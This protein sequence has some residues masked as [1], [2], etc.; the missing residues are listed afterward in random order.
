[1]TYKIS[2]TATDPTT[3]KARCRVSKGSETIQEYV[4]FSAALQIVKR[5]ADPGDRL[6]IDYGDGTTSEHDVIEEKYD[7]G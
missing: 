2:R 4:G 5:A 1:M 7:L 6:L 3:G